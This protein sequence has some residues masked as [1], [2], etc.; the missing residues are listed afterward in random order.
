V[1]FAD[2]IESITE[3]AE[4]KTGARVA[5]IGVAEPTELGRDS[6]DEI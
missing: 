5:L 1:G 3:R 4:E 6:S 2:T